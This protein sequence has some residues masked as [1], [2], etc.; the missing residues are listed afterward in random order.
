MKIH[1]LKSKFIGSLIGSA[2]GDQLGAAGK[3][4][5]DDTAM[6]IGVAESLIKNKGFNA[7]HLAKTFLDNYEME[8]WRGYGPGPPYIFN[9]IKA[10]MNWKKA[11]EK[12]YPG[13]S[14]G[15]GAAMRVAPIGLFYYDN[16]SRLNQIA[17]W[18]SRITHTHPWGMEGAALQAF[19]VALAVK[20]KTDQLDKQAFLEELKEF[21]EVD[22]YVKK[23]ER[24]RTLLSKATDRSRVVAEL[25]NTV[26]AFNS[27]P[28][29]IF[30]FLATSS[31]ESAIDY[32]FNLGGD[33][34]TISAMTGAIAGAYYGIECIPSKWRHKLENA[35]Y[36][37]Q[38]AEKLWQIKTTRG[39]DR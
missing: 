11:A 10:G 4:Y 16:K 3:Q 27:V 32:A 9:M 39:P 29:A 7:N 25:G 17:Y 23:L 33:R 5:T 38:L 31:F 19:T 22:I 35:G 37:E 36:I 8:P 13:G 34:D 26:E 30:S 28:I 24:I 12:I 21:S 2:I 20:I 15:N 18:S 14:Y 6:M 1:T